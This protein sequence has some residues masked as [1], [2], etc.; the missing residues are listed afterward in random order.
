MRETDPKRRD[1]LIWDFVLSFQGLMRNMARKRLRSWG[2]RVEPEDVVCHMNPLLFRRFKK[3]ADKGAY[4][5]RVKLKGYINACLGGE[6]IR[7]SRINGIDDSWDRI[8]G[9]RRKH[10]GQNL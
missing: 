5:K 6:I 2:R 10:E 3:A 8:A 4:Y 1:A 9:E 7:L